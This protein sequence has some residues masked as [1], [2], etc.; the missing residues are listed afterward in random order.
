RPG[1]LRAD[2]RP[3]ADGALV[4][5]PR[6][7]GSSLPRRSPALWHRRLGPVLPHRYIHARLV[8][9]AFRLPAVPGALRGAP[10]PAVHAALRA[11]ARPA[12]APRVW[13]WPAGP[14]AARAAPG[15]PGRR[16]AEPLLRTHTRLWTGRRAGAGPAL[17]LCR[18]AA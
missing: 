15:C 18:R 13:Q 6:H 1:L 2:V 16:S 8:R 5:Q 3:H 4:L 12:A 14:H 7:G 9:R 11:A 17:A 10:A